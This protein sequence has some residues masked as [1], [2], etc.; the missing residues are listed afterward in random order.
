MLTT[1]LALLDLFAD[2]VVSSYMRRLGFRHQL[3]IIENG[4]DEQQPFQA[5]LDDATLPQL[6]RSISKCDTFHAWKAATAAI[7]GCLFVSF[8]GVLAITG[9]NEP[10]LYWIAAGL[11][12]VQLFYVLLEVAR[13]YY[14][15]E[16]LRLQAQLPTSVEVRM[17]P[18]FPVP[19]QPRHAQDLAYYELPYMPL[20]RSFRV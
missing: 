14:I 15:E 18:L 2:D 13:A 12:T 8:S 7:A 6:N 1:L 11:V 5:Q 4:G 19:L 16:W 20:P 17:W 3:S 10:Y 9:T